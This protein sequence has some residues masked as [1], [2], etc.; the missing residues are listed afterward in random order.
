MNDLYPDIQ[1]YAT[2]SLP[3][4]ERH[5]LHVEEC[6]RLD[7]V[8]AVFLHGGPGAGCEPYHRR[9]FDPARYRVVLFD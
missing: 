2:H 7:G 5:T 1:P 6:G 8:P 4:D 9:F 3:V